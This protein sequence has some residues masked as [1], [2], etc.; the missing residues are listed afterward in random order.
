MSLMVLMLLDRSSSIWMISNLI[1][2][3][4]SEMLQQKSMQW[5]ISEGGLFG[6]GASFKRV[7]KK[8][9]D[10]ARHKCAIAL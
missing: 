3:L 1:F 6:E 7:K 8:K 4:V 10:K 2:S 5:I 9:E